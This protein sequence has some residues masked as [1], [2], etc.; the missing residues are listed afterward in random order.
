[1]ATRWHTKNV[2]KITQKEKKTVLS[3]PKDPRLNRHVLANKGLKNIHSQF[4]S[5]N[6]SQSPDGKGKYLMSTRIVRPDSYY[7]QSDTSGSCS[8]ILT[9]V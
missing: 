4:T 3:A 6:T 7:D 5:M 9:V 8:N 2:K 1:L